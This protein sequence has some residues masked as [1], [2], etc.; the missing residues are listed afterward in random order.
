MSDEEMTTTTSYRKSAAENTDPGSR[1]ENLDF[2]R[3]LIMASLQST[4]RET[5]LW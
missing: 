3:A 2:I 4:T 1:L 5:P